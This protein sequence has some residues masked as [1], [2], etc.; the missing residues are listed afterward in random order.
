MRT[1]TNH[2]LP[3][4]V[5]EVTD[6]EIT[7]YIGILIILGLTKKRNIDVDQIWSPSSIHY[8]EY[9]TLIMSR[10]RYQIISRYLTF[11][12]VDA[13]TAS[14]SK[15]RKMQYIFSEFQQKCSALF[16]PHSHVCIDETLYA[17]LGH[18][19]FRQ[20]M[21][22]KPAKYGINYFCMCDVETS[23]LCNIQVYLGRDTAQPQWNKIFICS[24]FWYN[25]CSV[26]ESYHL[27]IIW[28]T[29]FL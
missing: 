7:G 2:R 29:M 6:N 17:F 15:F 28:G 25:I 14:T 12:Y 4:D 5:P 10:N 19:S 18:C 9:V 1:C 13:S 11:D 24:F 22:K 27:S 8:F 26:R 20:Y 23:F 21:P 16:E 3:D